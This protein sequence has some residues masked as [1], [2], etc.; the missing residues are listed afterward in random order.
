M[1]DEF[2]EKEQ[3][4]FKKMFDL[5]DTDKSGAI[6]F[7]EMKNLSKH[8]GVE[9]PDDAL[10]ASIAKIDVDGNGELDFDEF[11]HWLHSAQNS[12]DDEFA[13]LK[14]KIRA[15]GSRNL[16]NSQIEQ[17]KE[18]FNH[19]DTDHSGSIDID[20]LGKVFDAMGQSLSKEELGQLIAQVDDDGSGEIE[21]QEFMLLMCSNF[22]NQR[23]FDQE[24]LEEF[25]RRDPSLTG[26]L[27]KAELKDMIKELCGSYLSDAEV[28]E[29]LTSADDRGD[30]TIEYMKWEALWEA[31]RS[32]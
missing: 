10:H 3:A 29:I 8:L 12:G 1:A 11:L 2:S 16:T 23:T 32:E 14:A 22:G 5:F 6:G 20:E 25:Q 28:D 9:L 19:F 13:S 4:Y 21:F 17:L 7:F 24:M 15:Q 18:V 26:I 27:T 30:G 31:C